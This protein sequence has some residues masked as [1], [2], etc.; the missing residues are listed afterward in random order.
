MDRVR[1]RDS[2]NVIAAGAQGST[3]VQGQA[4]EVA[5]TEAVQGSKKAAAAGR[6]FHSLSLIPNTQFPSSVVRRPSR[7]VAR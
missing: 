7:R 5:A 1:E 4:A 2:G 6:I 3:G